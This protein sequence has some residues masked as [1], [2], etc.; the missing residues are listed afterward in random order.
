MLTPQQITDTYYLEARC[1]ALEL[2][3]LL[4]RYDAATAR[5]GSPAPDTRKLEVLYE[6]FALLADKSQADRTESLL[7]IFT[8]I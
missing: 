6:S 1:M 7:A 4:D 3:A 8:K 5:T 2:A